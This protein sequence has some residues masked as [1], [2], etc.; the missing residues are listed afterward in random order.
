VGLYFVKIVVELHGGEVRA[1]S[2]RGRRIP[3]YGVCARQ[4]CPT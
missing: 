1:K 2:C 4:A 3:V